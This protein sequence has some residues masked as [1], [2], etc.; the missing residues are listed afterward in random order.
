MQHT[1]D[2]LAEHYEMYMVSTIKDPNSRYVEGTSA[3]TSLAIDI[4]S[5]EEHQKFQ[6]K[7]LQIHRDLNIIGAYLD[8]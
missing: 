4:L 8:Y 6:E 7:I 2:I 3:I 5:Q 1:S